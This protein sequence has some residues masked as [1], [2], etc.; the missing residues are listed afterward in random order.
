MLLPILCPSC[1]VM[2]S[3]DVSG[4]DAQTEHICPCGFRRPYGPQMIALRTFV[5]SGEAAYLPIRTIAERSA[6]LCIG[7]WWIPRKL[8]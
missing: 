7:A 1:Q 5:M 8:N 6:Q 4:I 3:V 2:Q